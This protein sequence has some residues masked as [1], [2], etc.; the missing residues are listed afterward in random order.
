MHYLP[1]EIWGEICSFACVD[2]GRTGRSLSLVSRFIHQVSKPYKLQSIVVIGERQV[3]A[4]ADL[5]EQTPSHLRRVD[6]IFLSPSPGHNRPASEYS[7]LER[8]LRAISSS[9]RIIHAV[10]ERVRPFVLLPV[11]LPVLEELVVQ[12]YIDPFTTVNDSVQFTALKHLTL[13][14]H[15]D[16]LKTVL[17]LTPSLIDL[18]MST[19][20]YHPRGWSA[21]AESRFPTR[22][23][24]IF[25]HTPSENRVAVHSEFGIPS[26]N[27]VML[28]L[29]AL[30]D[31]DHRISLFPPLQL[32]YPRMY[33]TEEIVAAWS[34]SV[35]GFSGGG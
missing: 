6:C 4:F 11:S 3:A 34:A 20:I 24:R 18:R 17:A 23:Q 21:A 32:S 1:D 30:S 7:T 26:Y 33:S 15:P 25:I 27:R 16:V 8:I 5:I 19:S 2:D 31:A 13:A 35:F 9:V 12:G 28:S 14:C 29:R 10:F 22:L